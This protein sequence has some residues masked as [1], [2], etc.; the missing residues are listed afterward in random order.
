MTEGRRYETL[1]DEQ[2]MVETEKRLK[3]MKRLLIE[4][5]D[6]LKSASGLE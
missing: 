1:S 4:I 5:R 2:V 6:A 3:E